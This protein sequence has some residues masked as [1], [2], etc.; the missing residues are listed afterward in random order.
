MHRDTG[1]KG[2][3]NRICTADYKILPIRKKVLELIGHKK[4]GR[5]PVEPKATVW[6][7]ISTDEAQRMKPSRYKFMKHMYPLIDA[8]MTRLHCLEWIKKNNYPT[9]PRSSC[10]ICPFHNDAEWA[11]LTS[12]EFEEACQFDEFIRDRGGGHLS[13]QLYLHKSCKPLRDVDLTDP[14]VN[15]L[16]MFG[17]ECEGMCGV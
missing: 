12:S 17:N 7:G 13:G 15:Q 2:M 8:G 5:F 14:F 9:P 11:N 6:I 3:I 4:H 16:S 1:K 10:I